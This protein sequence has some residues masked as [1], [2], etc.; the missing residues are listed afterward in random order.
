[1]DLGVWQTTPI[2]IV[3]KILFHTYKLILQEEHELVKKVYSKIFHYEANDFRIGDFKNSVLKG[4]IFNSE[5]ISFDEFSFLVKIKNNFLN[6]NDLKYLNFK[7]NLT[8]RNVDFFLDQEYF[9]SIIVC[10]R[11]R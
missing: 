2:L 9:R 4:K 6:I 3:E 1:M 8:Y 7:L 5:R 11:I 10:K